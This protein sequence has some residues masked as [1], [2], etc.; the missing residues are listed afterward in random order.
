MAETKKS[1]LFAD[2]MADRTGIDIEFTE[3]EVDETSKGEPLINLT[4]KEPRTFYGRRVRDELSGDNVKL[5]AADAERIS[6][7]ADTIEAIKKMEAEGEQ[8]FFWE[9]EGKSG[10]IKS[11]KLF[12]DVS[13][14]N[15]EAWITVTKFAKFGAQRRD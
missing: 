4:L 12:T 8:V 3:F 15:L 1:K 6:I 9:I 7:G 13:G 14:T 10:R 5:E 11:S 2:I